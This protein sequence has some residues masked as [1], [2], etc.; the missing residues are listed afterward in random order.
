M[1]KKLSF[2]T[3]KATIWLAISGCLL[4]LQ[5][6]TFGFSQITL[7][8][9]YLFKT[10][11]VSDNQTWVV[12]Q[13]D[14]DHQNL[15]NSLLLAELEAAGRGVQGIEA[16][17]WSDVTL[18]F[19]IYYSRVSTI[20]SQISLLEAKGEVPEEYRKHVEK[21][22][23]NRD[24][25]AQT[26]DTATMPDRQLIGAIR[27]TLAQVEGPIRELAVD[28]LSV[29]SLRADSERRATRNYMAIHI[30]LSI[31]TV[32]FLI[33]ISATIYLM[34]CDSRTRYQRLEKLLSAQD[35]LIRQ[36]PRALVL[37]DDEGNIRLSNTSFTKLL[38]W[39]EAEVLGRKIWE[40]FPI[41]RRPAWLT[42]THTHNP[43]NLRAGQSTTIRDIMI[44]KNGNRFPVEILVMHLLDTGRSSYLLMVRSIAVEQ[45]AM[46]ALR[47]D[48]TTAQ[49]MAFH[50]SRMLS[51]MSHE[52]RTPLHGIIAA[53]ELA[54]HQKLTPEATTLITVAQN[55]SQ[56]VLGYA[57]EVLDLVRIEQNPKSAL[58]TELS[59]IKIVCDSVDMLRP[60]AMRHGNVILTE[61]DNGVDKLV[62][63]HAE[64]L[65]Q[66]VSNLLSNAIKFTKDG[67]IFVRA[68]LQAGTNDLRI[69]VEDTGIGISPEHQDLIFSDFISHSEQGQS[70]W[71]G[72]GLGL[73]L[74]K[75]A[76]SVMGG[77]YGVSSQLGKGSLFWFTFPVKEAVEKTGDTEPEIVPSKITQPSSLK[78]LVVDDNDLNL[79]LVGKMLAIL[80]VGYDLASTGKE[81]VR[82]AGETRF[83]I[84]LLDIG[85]PEMDGYATAREIRKGGHSEDTHIIAFTADTSVD[86]K[87]EMF[88]HI[89]M[90]EL[91]LKPVTLDTLH[92]KIAL[93]Q[94]H[95][96]EVETKHIGRCSGQ[97]GAILDREILDQLVALD[98]LEGLGPL[99]HTLLNQAI[100][101][102][103]A[104]EKTTEDAI[105]QLSAE[106]HSLAGVAGMM[107][108]SLLSSV[109]REYETAIKNKSTD[110]TDLTARFN[111]T[112]EVTK[113]EFSS[114]QKQHAMIS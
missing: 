65:R 11:V 76:V 47:C 53:L 111:R 32:V 12:S 71:K 57:D 31:L 98:G 56:T 49:K 96:R 104:L 14:V 41:K 62:T 74:F 36:I 21:I 23:N 110:M 69:E 48:R 44:D 39:T 80:G 8:R 73:G 85:M 17:M 37:I 54:K 70:R 29:L 93:C 13:L 94:D 51:V 16:D 113:A 102:Q 19:D 24:V 75:R 50:N 95:F 4:S 87:G 1:L 81:A 2:S 55:A 108:A 68:L 45:R 107:G 22:I 28:T 34:L 7:Y 92:K 3:P 5:I 64:T 46:R 67:K 106:F 79:K 114:L 72:T 59:P 82:K 77:Q 100:E 30:A 88:R 103:D 15:E 10:G 25:L 58:Q 84:V 6:I 101:L 9:A 27:S 105:G 86:P 66:S 97:P 35:D 89:G 91:L 63:V 52:I 83:D 38:G 40:I 18:A 78:I 20:K 112:V 26:L 109:A 42:D 60:A 33:A 43:F 90:D 99:V 61:F